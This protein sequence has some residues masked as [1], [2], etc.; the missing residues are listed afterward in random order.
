MG[1][2]ITKSRLR[3]IIREEIAKTAKAMLN[4]SMTN[5]NTWNHIQPQHEGCACCNDTGSVACPECVGV[6]GDV[7]LDCDTC[8][9]SG[10]SEC[11][12]CG[13]IAL[14]TDFDHDE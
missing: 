4:E 1:L 11:D 8:L 5:F 3:M 12:A 2:K 6:Y 7:N 9:G 10:E 14:E 13:A